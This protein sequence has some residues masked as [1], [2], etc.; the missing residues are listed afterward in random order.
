MKRKGLVY[1]AQKLNKKRQKQL[2]TAK[3]VI[4]I[5]LTAGVCIGLGMST[6][7]LVPAPI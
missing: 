2:S 4:K 6:G 1:Y 3:G 7:N 5:T